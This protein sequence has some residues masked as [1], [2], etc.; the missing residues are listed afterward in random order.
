VPWHRIVWCLC[1]ERKKRVAETPTS[2]SKT[3]SF[4]PFRDNRDKN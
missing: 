1:E 2:S 4:S 3:K